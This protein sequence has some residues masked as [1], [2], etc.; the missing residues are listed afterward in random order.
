[1]VPTRVIVTFD[2]PLD[3]GSTA[4]G[5]WSGLT[6]PPANL[7]FIGAEDGDVEGR[8]VIVKLNFPAPQPGPGSVSYAAAPADLRNR[9]LQKA[10]AFADFPLT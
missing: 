4:A 7:R 9:F 8:E 1:M 5:N 6:G 2:Q 10:P 3:P